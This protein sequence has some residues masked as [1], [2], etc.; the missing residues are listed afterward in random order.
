MQL[1]VPSV[2]GL[3]PREFGAGTPLNPKRLVHD[4]LAELG[5]PSLAIT[6]GG[7]LEFVFQTPMFD[8]YFPSGQAQVVG[9]VDTRVS[10]CHVAPGGVSQ[11]RVPVASA[12]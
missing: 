1:F 9:S 5:L 7:F 11:L 4:R 12:C 8:L 2:F 3:S 10:S 6:T